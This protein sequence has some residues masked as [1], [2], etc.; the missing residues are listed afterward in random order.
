MKVWIVLGDS[1]S[2]DHWVIAFGHKPT[3]EEL[4]EL[5]WEWDGDEFEEGP[6]DYGSWVY[7]Q[8]E[9]QELRI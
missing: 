3:E 8:V 5:A 1:E 7:L 4:K 9:E 6:G 2:G